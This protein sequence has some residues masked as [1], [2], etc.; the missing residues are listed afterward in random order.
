MGEENF[1]WK[2]YKHYKYSCSDSIVSSHIQ[3]TSAQMHGTIVLK[4]KYDD[5]GSLKEMKTDQSNCLN[6]TSSNTIKAA[7]L[8][9]EKL[10]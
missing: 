9:L 1:E 10:I 7:M 8:D 3:D 6:S 2:T 4:D 5:N